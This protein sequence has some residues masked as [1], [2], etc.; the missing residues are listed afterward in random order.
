M[1]IKLK[2]L[3]LKALNW[4]LSVSL[5]RQIRI[6]Q[7]YM[8]NINEFLITMSF[9]ELNKYAVKKEN[10]QD[11]NKKFMNLIDKDGELYMYTVYKYNE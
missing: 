2:A 11:Y 1:C 9:K 10:K 7:Y 4:R 5:I 8:Y 6:L 3:K